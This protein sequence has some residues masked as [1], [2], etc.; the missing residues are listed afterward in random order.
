[1]TA[2]DLVAGV[3]P[4]SDLVSASVDGISG[5][6]VEGKVGFVGETGRFAAQ[7]G[8]SDA[9]DPGISRSSDIPDGGSR[10]S[11]RTTT[12]ASMKDGGPASASMKD[13]G[14]S[15]ATASMKDD[16]TSP[17]V[18]AIPAKGVGGIGA[19]AASDRV[20]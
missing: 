16:G 20:A 14:P 12:D 8:V 10:V 15:M 9:G 2:A 17:C 6:E 5:A 3:L 11:G 13:G 18:V 7:E 4:A 19:A 1:M